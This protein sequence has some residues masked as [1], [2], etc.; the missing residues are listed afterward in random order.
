MLRT[1]LQNVEQ[2]RKRVIMR[3]LEI[4]KINYLSHGLGVT[5]NACTV[6]TAISL[7]TKICLDVEVT[8]D[9]CQQCQK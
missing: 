7:D 8:S 4:I 5:H 3:M 9:K 2:E 1:F 6:V